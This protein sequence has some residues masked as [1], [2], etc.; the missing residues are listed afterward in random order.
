[1]VD[2]SSAKETH[3]FSDFTFGIL[4]EIW[5]NPAAPKGYLANQ[6]K[7]ALLRLVWGRNFK[8]MLI[9]DRWSNEQ[10]AQL[11]KKVLKLAADLPE[12]FLFQLSAMRL[13]SLADEL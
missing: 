9:Q 12:S 7:I 6:G 4:A 8:K 13:K 11:K 2:M 10:R 1:M 3:S 5:L